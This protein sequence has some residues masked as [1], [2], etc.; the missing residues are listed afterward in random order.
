M[1]KRVLK[2][3]KEDKSAAAGLAIPAGIFLGMGIGFLVDKF[4]AAMFIGMGA[5][6]L[7][8]ALIELV[9]KK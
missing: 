3:R 9:R 5:G 6:F 7:L 4:I 2:K 8:A 1:K